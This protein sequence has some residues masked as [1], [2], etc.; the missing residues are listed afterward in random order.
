VW[1]SLGDL[2]TFAGENIKDSNNMPLYQLWCKSCFKP[3]EVTMT[4]KELDIF[5]KGKESIPCPECKKPLKKLICPPR[6][7]KIN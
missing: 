2:K 5:D 6:R 4:L 3:Y 1:F 7:I